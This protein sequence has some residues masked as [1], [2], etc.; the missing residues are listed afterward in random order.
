[1]CSFV[2]VAAC[3][4]KSSN[5]PCLVSQSFSF[6]DNGLLDKIF[7]LVRSL[8][9]RYSS[10]VNV[11]HVCSSLSNSTSV[12]IFDKRSPSKFRVIRFEFRLVGQIFLFGRRDF[13][14]RLIV[15]GLTKKR[16]VVH[17]CVNLL[18]LDRLVKFRWKTNIKRILGILFRRNTISHRQKRKKEKE[19]TEFDNV[20]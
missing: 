18:K 4:A 12:S 1:M 2:D 5:I 20:K 19:K 3:A 14:T 15:T 8:V 13:L 6:V 16:N 7:L 9:K 17:T 11:G 10:V